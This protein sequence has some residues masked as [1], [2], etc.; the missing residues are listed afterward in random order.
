MLRL[1]A[2]ADNVA[3]E[4]YRR[5]QFSLRTLLISVVAVSF[6]LAAM[7]S[8]SLG[9][10]IATVSV[11]VLLLLFSVV[12]AVYRRPFWVGFAICGIGYLMLTVIPFT[13]KLHAFLITSQ[14]VWFSLT[15][16]HPPSNYPAGTDYGRVTEHFLL[17]GDCL[18]ALILAAIG[19]LLARFAARHRRVQIAG[20][21]SR[22]IHSENGR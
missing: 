10:A 9:W 8:A 17:I 7:R 18:W 12:L 1:T 11:T 15:K 20:E 14:S 3:M 16:L 21:T 22:P 13:S 19:G 6:A 4:N 2:P 5:I